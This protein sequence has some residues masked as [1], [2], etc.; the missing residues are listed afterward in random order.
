MFRTMTRNGGEKRVRLRIAGIGG[1]R[2][3]GRAGFSLVELL[4]VVALMAMAA[5]VGVPWFVR[6]SQRSQLRSDAYEIQAALMAARM[7]AIK[8]NSPAS[9]TIT[10][11]TGAQDSHEIDTV[12]AAIPDPPPPTPTPVPYSPKFMVP[13]HHLAFIQTPAGGVI[14]FRSDGTLQAPPFPTPGVIVVAGPPPNNLN[15]ITI[16]AD[17]SGHVRVI[18]PVTWN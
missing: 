6:I 14:T 18:T 13:V 3:R 7:G 1:I 16:Q 9:V 10:V 15:Q 17:P 5:L 4:V 8:R 2:V 11:A 12:Y